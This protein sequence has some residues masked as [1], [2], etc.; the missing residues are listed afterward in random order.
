MVAAGTV[1]AQTSWKCTSAHGGT[2]GSTAITFIKHVA[3]DVRVATTTAGTLASSFENGDT[4]NG[5]V[6]A[7]GNRILI[8]NQTAPAEN[9]I[10]TVN[11]SG[12]PTRA[13]DMDAWAEVPDIIVKALEGTTDSRVYW[14][15]TSAAG[16]TLNTTAITFVEYNVY[17]FTGNTFTSY[18]ATDTTSAA[19]YNNTGGRLTLNIGGGGGT[20]TIRNGYGATTVINNTVTLTVTVLDKADNGPIKLA[21]VAI[22]RTSDDV[23]LMNEDTETVTTGAFVV[24]VLYRIVNVGD[25][26]FTLIG[27]ASNTVGVVFTATGVGGGTT[28]TATNGIAIDTSFNYVSNTPIYV[29]IRKSLAGETKYVPLSTTGTITATGY[30]LTVTMTQDTNA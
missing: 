2:L 11:A 13:T 15:C 19:I 7:T 6:L 8:K 23:Q 12:A 24:G 25:T 27:A 22:Y 9:G 5:V 1:N 20:P 17:S 30:T 10:Y 21:Q 3:L 16:G 29:R 4:V 28:G 14:D 26:N 18:G